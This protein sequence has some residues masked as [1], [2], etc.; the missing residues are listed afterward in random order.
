MLQYF[1]KLELYLILIKNIKCIHN[2]NNIQ[3]SI[4]EILTQI[5]LG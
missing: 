4:A 1:N 3:F 5:K 2:N